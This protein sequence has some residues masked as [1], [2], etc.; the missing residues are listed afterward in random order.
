[1]GA[2]VPRIYLHVPSCNSV[3]THCM[4]LPLVRPVDL[5]AETGVRPGVLSLSR[6]GRDRCNS[7]RNPSIPSLLDAR[8]PN[9][10]SQNSASSRGNHLLPV[11]CWLTSLRSPPL[12]RD[13][14]TVRLVPTAT[15]G[16]LGTSPFESFLAH[17]DLRMPHQSSLE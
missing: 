3:R 5:L 9:S 14:R 12:K 13:I 17:R 4:P 1:M 16:T 8:S 15:S 6:T 10:C 7:E 11:H 2:T